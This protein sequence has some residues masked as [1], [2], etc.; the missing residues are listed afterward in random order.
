MSQ[1]TAILGECPDVRIATRPYQRPS[2]EPK[3]LLG[4]KAAAYPY[5]APDRLTDSRLPRTPI[6]FDNRTLLNDE[7]RSRFLRC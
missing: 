7:R 1:A 5:T 3:E 6:P 4:D 2:M